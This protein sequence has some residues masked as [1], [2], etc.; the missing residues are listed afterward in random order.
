MLMASTAA[1]SQDIYFGIGGGAGTKSGIGDNLEAKMNFGVHARAFVDFNESF[2]FV[3]GL[4]YFVPS[5]TTFLSQ[6]VKMN[7]MLFN[8][9]ALYY[10]QNDEDMQL[11]ALGGLNYGS[12]KLDIAGESVKTNVTNWEVGA[13][14]KIGKIFMEA[15][16]DSGEKQ[17]IALIGIYF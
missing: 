9:D 5:K 13:G 15:K 1:F 8:A 14:A 17:I 3:G 11:Y 16:Y 4:T 10:I 2:G 12:A 6:D 7:Y